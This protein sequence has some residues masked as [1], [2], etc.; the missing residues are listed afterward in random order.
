MADNQ[1]LKNIEIQYENY[2][3]F[4]T[5]KFLTREVNMADFYWSV[6][7]DLENEIDIMMKKEMYLSN[8]FTAHR[9]DLLLMK[10]NSYFIKYLQAYVEDLKRQKS[11]FS[12][13]L[14]AVKETST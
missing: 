4:K 6:L 14:D 1:S 2:S 8:Y 3:K 9:L 10:Y 12:N 11:T 7:K 5:H 13:V